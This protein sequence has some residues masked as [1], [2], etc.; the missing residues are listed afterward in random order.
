[1]KKK[2]CWI[3]SQSLSIISKCYIRALKHLRLRLN[4][5]FSK[6]SVPVRAHLFTVRINGSPLRCSWRV[7]TCVW[8]GASTR[9][10]GPRCRRHTSWP[11]TSSSW[12]SEPSRSLLGLISGP[13]SG[14]GESVYVPNKL[15]WLLTF[16]LCCQLE[17]TKLTIFIPDQI[18]HELLKAGN[19]HPHLSIVDMTS[20]IW[21]PTAHVRLKVTSYKMHF[22]N[23]TGVS[24][25]PQSMREDHP[26][27]F[28]PAP[29]ISKPV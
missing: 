2:R 27:S 15:L 8:W 16:G 3:S 19:T 9:G 23:I 10:G 14:E 11:C 12:R 20:H 22:L 7:T 24:R 26:L 18:T 29:I 25:D 17:E 6:C 13:S 4:W 1:M 28:P 5:K 21:R